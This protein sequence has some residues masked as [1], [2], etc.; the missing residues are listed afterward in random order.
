VIVVS[1]ELS[2]S[3]DDPVLKIAVALSD[4]LLV[5]R[6]SVSVK[7]PLPELKASAIGLGQLPSS[8]EEGGT[9]RTLSSCT[10]WSEE[11]M[12]VKPNQEGRGQQAMNDTETRQLRWYAC[13][14]VCRK[15]KSE[16][17]SASDGLPFLAVACLL[18]LVL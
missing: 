9:G 8:G 15:T 11:C 5:S 6:P 4:K 10:D 12:V 17:W 14:Y 16:H 18:E 7:E 3:L 13:L 2:L 1:I